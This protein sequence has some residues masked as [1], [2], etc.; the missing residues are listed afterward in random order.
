MLRSWTLKWDTIRS[1]AL[2]NTDP[3]SRTITFTIM[4]HGALVT[5]SQSKRQLYWES[6][7]SLPR[8][9][10][11]RKLL[12]LR[13]QSFLK[14]SEIGV[15]L[16]HVYDDSL[17]KYHGPKNLFLSV[18]TMMLL[19]KDHSTQSGTMLL[20]VKSLKQFTHI[21]PTKAEALL[22]LWIVWWKLSLNLVPLWEIWIKHLELPAK[23]DY[24][25]WTVFRMSNALVFPLRK[26]M[27]C[28]ATIPS[29]LNKRSDQSL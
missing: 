16:M 10:L 15:S 5:Q 3:I 25:R 27:V 20:F 6:F 19:S 24:N 18:R 8:T 23:N 13:G 2:L 29:A 21:V 7:I 11:I 14:N 1:H 9:P 17:P 22:A 26:L 4:F 28:L 12:L